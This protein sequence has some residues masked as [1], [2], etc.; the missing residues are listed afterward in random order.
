[1]DDEIWLEVGEILRKG[2]KHLWIP[3]ITHSAVQTKRRPLLHQLVK[4]GLNE[5][6]SSSAVP[7]VNGHRLHLKLR[8]R[9]YHRWD[10]RLAN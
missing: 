9:R 3:I 6:V 1:M 8:T 5:R 10:E 4:L 2:G 7:T